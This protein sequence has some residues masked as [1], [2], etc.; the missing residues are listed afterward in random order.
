MQVLVVGIIRTTLVTSVATIAVWIL[1]AWLRVRS[2]LA[3]RSAW[4]LVIVQGWLL[5]SWTWRVEFQRANANDSAAPVLEVIHQSNAVVR[6][7]VL[8]NASQLPTLVTLELFL[9]LALAAWGMGMLLLVTIGLAQYCKMFFAAPPGEVPSNPEWKAELIQVRCACTL[10]SSI[11]LRV[12]HQLGPLVCWVPRVFLVLVPRALWAKLARAQRVAILHHELAHCER[13]DLWKN[14]AVRLLALPQWFNPL[15]WLAVQKFEEAGEWACDERAARAM[16]NSTTDYARTLVQVADFAARVPCGTVGITGG[17]LSRRVKRVLQISNKE[18]HE[19]RGFIVSVLLVA[20]ALLQAVRIERVTADEPP[21]IVPPKSIEPE[22]EKVRWNPKQPYVI[23]P[24]DVL[25]ID[26]TKVD[27]KKP[28][29]I[30]SFDG[31]FVRAEGVN[32]GHP[33]DNS[34]SVDTE[35]N[36]DLGPNYGTIRVA[37]FLVDEAEQLIRRHLV[38]AHPNAKV[39][40]TLAFAGSAHQ[41]IGEH[42]VGPDGRVSLGNFGTVYVTGLTLEEATAAIEK[43]L[44]DKLL[45]PEVKVKVLAY[46]SKKAYLVFRGKGKVDEIV[47][48]PITGNDTVLDALATM[49]GEMAGKPNLW[50]ARPA[51]PGEMVVKILPVDYDAITLR[52][53]TSTNYQLLPGDR[54]FF[55]YARDAND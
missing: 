10:R 14:L 27:P 2:P 8:P 52:G 20:V 16:G 55:E 21:A 11:E 7:I 22:S 38:K 23:E 48:M 29:K 50:V 40:V 31:L 24:P 5:W 1:L 33:I 15:V 9:N 34:Y 47:A 49:K 3:H 13:G 35:G 42:L 6:A 43:K 46:N 41:F 17:E 37:N 12:T 32:A 53:D 45:D 54:L 28:H 4:V 44:S 39:T 19:M 36:I 26:A 18:V 51:A 30:E 25:L